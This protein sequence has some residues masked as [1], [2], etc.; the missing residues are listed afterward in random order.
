LTP[1][2][3]QKQCVGH[4]IRL[5]ASPTTTAGSRP[6]L[7][8]A[9]AAGFFNLT[10]DPDYGKDHDRSRNLLGGAIHGWAQPPRCRIRW[11][12]NDGAHA[13]ILS[14]CRSHAICGDGRH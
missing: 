10:L 12:F 13:Q 11:K 4:T 1:D 2:P 9:I 8:P 6:L 14:G 5:S 3:D 7:R